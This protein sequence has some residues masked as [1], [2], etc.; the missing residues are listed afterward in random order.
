LP[1]TEEYIVWIETIA[2]IPTVVKATSPKH[3]QC[4]VGETLEDGTLSEISRTLDSYIRYDGP[5]GGPED[6][7]IVRLADFF[8]IPTPKADSPGQS[9]GGTP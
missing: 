5:D 8:S 7:D 6:W 1:D 4:I 3:A 9:E 2:S